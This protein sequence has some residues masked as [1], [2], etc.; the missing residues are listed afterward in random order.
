MHRD[1]DSFYSPCRLLHAIRLAPAPRQGPDLDHRR[2]ALAITRRHIIS[3]LNISIFLQPGARRRSSWPTERRS[4][5]LEST[6]AMLWCERLRIAGFA[7]LN[8]R[9]LSI[10]CATGG[11]SP[12]SALA[13]DESMLIL[14]SRRTHTFIDVVHAYVACC[15]ACIGRLLWILAC[16]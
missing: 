6:D 14:L 11:S 10:R 2:S 16:C 1:S 15:G 9:S 7:G 8:V 12:L 3:D 5:Q 4:A 13:L